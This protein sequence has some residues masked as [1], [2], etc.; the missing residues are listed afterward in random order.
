MAVRL[1][2]KQATYRFCAIASAFDDDDLAAGRRDT[3]QRKN[4]RAVRDNEEV[5]TRCPFGDERT[6]AR[7]QGLAL[8]AQHHDI[9]EG[10]LGF[11]RP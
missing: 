2:E 6:G 7:R 9:A 10:R 5:S 4:I 1:I 3:G 8:I 11:D